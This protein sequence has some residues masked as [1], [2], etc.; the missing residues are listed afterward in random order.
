MKGFSKSNEGMT[1][2]EL[3]V[4]VAVLSILMGGAMALM[5]QAA[6]YHGD[7]AREVEIQNQLQTAFVQVGNLMIDANIGIEYDTARGRMISCHNDFFY[8]VEKHDSK[9]YVDQVNYTSTATTVDMKLQEART[10]VMTPKENNLLSDRVTTFLVDTSGQDEGYVVLAM[11][12]TYKNRSA[13]LSQNVFLRNSDSG[14]TIL[15]GGTHSVTLVAQPCP[16]DPTIYYVDISSVNGKNIISLQMTGAN[17]TA[18]TLA[19]LYQTGSG[20]DINSVTS[21]TVSAL[22]SALSQTCNT[23]DAAITFEPAIS[24]NGNYLI[25]TMNSANKPDQVIITYKEAEE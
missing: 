3:L 18:K 17:K 16:A 20:V 12:C 9:L 1:L 2:V 23:N 21:S 11:R 22:S 8:V 15:A 5:K 13:Y 14:S 6:T 10:Y 24:F 25:I 7:S 19:T 4:S